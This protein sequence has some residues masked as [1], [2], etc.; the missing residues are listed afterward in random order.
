[1]KNQFQLGPKSFRTITLLTGLTLALSAAFAQAEEK[2]EFQVAGTFVEGCSCEL[3]C[4]CAMGRMNHGCQGVGAMVLTSGSYN[5]VDLTGAKF[6]YATAPG[7][8]VRLY[9]DARDQRQQEALSGFTKS[10]FSAFGKIEAVKNAKIELSGKGGKYTLSVDGGKIAQLTTEPV[11]GAD[12]KTPFTYSN[13]VVPVSPTLMQGKTI[14]GSY[15]DGEHS[16]TLAGSNSYFNGNA[17]NS[18]KI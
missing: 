14:K 10:S 3:V 11:L 9:L 17:H 4:P 7:G 12:Q 16:F 2:H 8:W 18:G 1:M 5:G 6:V 13:T 15:H